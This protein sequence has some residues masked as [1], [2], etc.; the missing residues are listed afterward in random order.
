MFGITNF[1]A[2][3]AFGLLYGF[4]SG[5]CSSARYTLPVISAKSRFRCVPY[6]FAI[7][8]A[9]LSRWRAWVG[10]VVYC[11][12]DAQII[13]VEHEWGSPSQSLVYLSL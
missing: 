12:A 10:G 5:S 3:V 13:C 1:P 9:E 6:T 4:W 7:S 8:S 2:V 11:L